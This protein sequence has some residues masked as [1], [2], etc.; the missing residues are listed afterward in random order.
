[1]ITPH[2]RKEECVEGNAPLPAIAFEKLGGLRARLRFS[3]Q[4]HTPLFV[5][6]YVPRQVIDQLCVHIAASEESHSFLDERSLL[7]WR[8]DLDMNS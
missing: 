2:K 5:G 1:M 8:V 7:Q 3:Q 6:K 4:R